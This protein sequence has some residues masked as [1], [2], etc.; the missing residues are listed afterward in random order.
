MS[1]E[2]IVV[3]PWERRAV[4]TRPVPIVFAEKMVSAARPCGI[5]LVQPRRSFPVGIPAIVRMV[6]E[7]VPGIAAS[8]MVPLA[9]RP[10]PARSASVIW[11]PSAVPMSGM[12]TVLNGHLWSVLTSVGSV[13]PNV[14]MGFANWMRTAKHAVRIVGNAKLSN[15]AVVV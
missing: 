7:I 5:Q 4:T 11:I 10:E 2:V 13:L 12:P 15:R 9:A 3:E 14:V 8:P 6:W 1:L